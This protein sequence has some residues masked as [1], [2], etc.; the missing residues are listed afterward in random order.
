MPENGSPPAASYPSPGARSER[1]AAAGQ[2]KLM[3]RA[4]YAAVTVALVLVAIK[5]AAWLATGAVAML[6]SLV[7]SLL[8]AVAS[9]ANLV[10]IR[11]AITPADTEHRFG[12]GKAEPLAGLAQA[13][14]I[15]SSVGFLVVQAAQR[16]LHPQPL[17]ESLTGI[18]VIGVSILLTLGLVLYQRHVIRRTESVAIS[19]DR[20]HYA[21]DLLANL[22]V[23]LAL[24]LGGM[25]L[26]WAD[27]LIALAIAG[28]IGWTA[29]SILRAA[30]DQLMDRELPESQRA[31]IRRIAAAHPEVIAIHDLRTR[32]SGL[33]VFI[34]LHA[35]MAPHLPLIE[36]HRIADDLEA[37]IR[38]AFP[39]AEV[40]VHQ[41]PAG[42]AERPAFE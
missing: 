41:D 1:S 40:I 36:A 24:V 38:A 29:W 34:Q 30:F 2:A 19:A 32:R 26:V 14:I 28:Y 17:A 9:T 8:D 21:G 42:V 35:V 37:Q 20:L 12:H 7:D 13:V 25:G 15:L 6:G 31:R 27:P 3:R 39:R 11:H 18:A 33:R 10:A 22:G 23:V 5:T 4:S 16:L